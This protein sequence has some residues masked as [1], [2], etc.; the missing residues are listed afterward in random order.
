MDTR[1]GE[2]ISF[3]ELKKKPTQEQKWFKEVPETYQHYLDGLNRKERRE[4]YRKNKHL[5]KDI[6]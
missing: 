5:F 6:V 4:W 2:I 1:T 3:E